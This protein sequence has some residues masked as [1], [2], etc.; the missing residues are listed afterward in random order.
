[1]SDRYHGMPASESETFR[2]DADP[3]SKVRAIVTTLLP[4]AVVLLP[5]STSTVADSN[6][7]WLTVVFLS[8][9]VILA[10][11]TT[12]AVVL[13]RTFPMSPSTLAAVVLAPAMLVSLAASPSQRGTL[14]TVVAIAAAAIA[15]AISLQRTVDLGR[16][17]AVPLLITSSVQSLLV[18][19]QTVTDRAIGLNLLDSGASLQTIDG[20]LRAQG[21]MNHVYEPAAL[22]LLAGSVA[23]VTAPQQPRTRW[24][25]IAGAAL[26]GSTI[27][28]THS[29]AALLGV[30]LM[31]I[32]LIA[33]VL[34]RQTAPAIVGAAF[35]VGFLIAAACSW[36][37]WSVRADHSTTGGL[38]E[39]S[40]G[41]VTLS[42]QAIQ[43]AA[44]HPFV[45]VGPGLYLETMRTDYELDDRYPFIVHNVSLA[46]A[47]ENGI[48]ASVLASFLVTW[49]IIRAVRHRPVWAALALAPIGFLLFD[50]LHYDRPVGLLLTGIW[51]GVL[52]HGP[53]QESTT[54]RRVRSS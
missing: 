28:L 18:I 1:M 8:I 6:L 14:V 30:G 34:R 7:A 13:T 35:V 52:H 16:T 43:M 2:S 54:S 10:V 5:L 48:A 53:G 37:A 27:G 38:D 3:V 23:I 41:R 29:R 20:L 49:A 42:Q 26:A 9:L 39:A 12:A 33:P 19:A 25:W 51:L 47:A 46:V 24:L 11:A 45:G 17:V 36:S 31:G 22:A 15:V 21:T 32:F 40:L 50:V 44:D 4:F